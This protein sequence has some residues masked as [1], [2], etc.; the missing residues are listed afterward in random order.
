MRNIKKEKNTSIGLAHSLDSLISS[1]NALN[2]SLDEIPSFKAESSDW[3]VAI[4][5]ETYPNLNIGDANYRHIGI[6]INYTRSSAVGKWKRNFC[7]VLEH[8][9]IV[10][11]AN[12]ISI[13]F[14]GP[15]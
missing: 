8:H 11:S 14:M 9:V 6:D 3:V 12:H 1:A 7:I 4:E 15:I 13:F 10:L 2:D 5:F